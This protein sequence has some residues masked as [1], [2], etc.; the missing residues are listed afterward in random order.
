MQMRG[1]QTKKM[2]SQHVGGKEHLAW[3]RIVKGAFI[4]HI[5]YIPDR[6]SVGYGVRNASKKIKVIVLILPMRWVIL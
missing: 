2:A 5:P 1:W 4:E 3:K 6:Y